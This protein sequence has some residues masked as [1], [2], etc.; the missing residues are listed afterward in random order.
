MIEADVFKELE[1]VFSVWYAIAPANTK[2]PYL[3]YTNVT[4]TKSNTFCS[5]AET[6]TTI[7]LDSYSHSALDAKQQGLKALKLLSGFYPVNYSAGGSYEEETGL[8]RFQMEF[9]FI[10]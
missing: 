9:S 8:Y 7:Q 5:F 4:E 10:Y 2:P 6:T 1:K 3:V